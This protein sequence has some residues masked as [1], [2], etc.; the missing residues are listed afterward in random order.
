[1]KTVVLNN[2]DGMVIG[3]LPH[4][5]KNSAGHRQPGGVV[6]LLPGANLVDSDQLATLRKNPG[7]EQYF[8]VTIQPSPAP[9][10]SPER[11][12]KKE[13]EIICEG[14]DDQAPIV[15]LKDPGMALKV[16]GETLTNE[17]LDVW[18]RQEQRPAIREAIEKQRS[19]NNGI[20]PPRA[21]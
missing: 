16:I 20:T 6:V 12:G 11:V 1:M 15:K 2:K 21:A 7:F 4:G 9:E 19:K 8:N 18:L 17:P 10:Q 5:E 13:L 14:V 3:Q